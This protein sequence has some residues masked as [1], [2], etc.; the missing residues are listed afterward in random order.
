MENDTN[1]KFAEA[2]ENLQRKTRDWV[3]YRDCHEYDM[4]TVA[5]ES[6]L[7]IEK[8][9]VN[10]LMDLKNPPKRICHN[11]IV[12]EVNYDEKELNYIHATDVADYD[13]HRLRHIF[14]RVE[15]PK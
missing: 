2:M 9:V 10:H 15:M 13:N 1:F 14:Y 5:Y 11:G 4:T 3:H 6:M 12:Y 7:A 8:T